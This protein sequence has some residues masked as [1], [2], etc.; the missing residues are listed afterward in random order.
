MNEKVTIISRKA[1]NEI[2]KSWDA[3]LIEKQNSLLVFK[4][5]FEAEIRHRFLGVIRPGT[6]SYEYYWSD[7]WFN[8][9]RFHEPDGSFRNFYCNVNTPPKFA[10]NV[11]DY[12]D[13]DIDIIVWRDLSYSILD[14]DEY[15]QNSVIFNYS[16]EFKKEGKEA[17]NK[18]VFMI[19]NKLFPFDFQIK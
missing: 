1:D 8:V 13:L 2:S 10:N 12:V 3:E 9:F 19:E 14:L 11:L 4:G 18:L 17:L 16:N 15:E 5:K 6:I 7:S